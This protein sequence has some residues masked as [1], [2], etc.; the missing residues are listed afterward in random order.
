MNTATRA[1]ARQTDAEIAGDY[2]S[3]RGRRLKLGE[4]CKPEL[5]EAAHVDELRQ[6]M[7]T[8]R[9]FEHLVADDWFHPDLL[10]LVCEEF[11]LATQE[12][13][14]SVR[15]LHEKT[16][17]S[18][19]GS[20]PGPACE[21]YF[22]LVHSTRFMR[23]LAAISGVDH[24]ICDPKLYSGGLHETRR[25]GHFDI[26]RDFDRHAQYGLHNEMVLITYLNEDWKPSWGGALELWD[27]QATGCV[28]KIEPE[29]G[30]TVVMRH[31]PTS[32]HGHPLPL[33]AP[34]ERPRR[35]VAAYYYS[36]RLA[37][38][39]VARRQTTTFLSPS[40]THLVVE[41]ARDWMPPVVWGALRRM[42]GG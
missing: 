24:L 9:P 8:A 10:A 31:G 11:D 29:F 42:S 35:S 15:S 38:Q 23:L 4:L 16:R 19:P 28:R 6:R 30:R 41:F 34:N 22:S 17:R 32:Y 27:A 37:V 2:I 33:D 25:G 18:R 7:R 36:N 20:L 21:L 1:L 12:N 39:E 3:I 13:W 14:R 26:H 40:H 5:F